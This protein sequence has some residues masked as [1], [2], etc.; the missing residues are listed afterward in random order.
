V[1]GGDEEG[2]VV[3][4]AATIPQS[5]CYLGLLEILD[6]E[7]VRCVV[8]GGGFGRSGGFW[9]RGGNGRGFG[10]FTESVPRGVGHCV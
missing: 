3:P 8:D 9:G 1:G 10:G 7:G 2:S 5:C 6:G 4:K